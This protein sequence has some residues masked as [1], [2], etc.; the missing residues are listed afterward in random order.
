[1]KY[2]LAVG[3]RWLLV[4]VSSWYIVRRLFLEHRVFFG[5]CAWC[6]LRTA[7]LYSI[8]SLSFTAC[9]CLHGKTCLV[10]SWNSVL[11]LW[12][13]VPG[14]LIERGRSVYDIASFS[15]KL[16]AR[17]LVAYFMSFG[18]TRLSLAFESE[19]QIS[20]TA[21]VYS[22]FLVWLVWYNFLTVFAFETIHILKRSEKVEE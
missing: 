4:N 21:L 16:S 13:S 7:S 1:M 18:F 6:L 20:Y 17:V 3:R 8:A 2:R 14:V 15:V 22:A 5:K 11:S 9:S 19:F 12:Y 10:L